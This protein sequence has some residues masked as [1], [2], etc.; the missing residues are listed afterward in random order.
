MRAVGA[1]RTPQDFKSR[2]ERAAKDVP[3]LRH[4][5]ASQWLIRGALN[6]QE[7]MLEWRIAYL[8]NIIYRA[9]PSIMGQAQHT[10]SICWAPPTW[11]N[12]LYSSA[13]RG[14]ACLPGAH[15]PGCHGAL[16]SGGGR[17]DRR[18]CGCSTT[19]VC[20]QMIL[21][22]PISNGGLQPRATQRNE[23]TVFHDGMTNR[24]DL[25]RKPKDRTH[26]PGSCCKNMHSGPLAPLSP[27]PCAGKCRLPRARPAPQT[28]P[29][30]TAPPGGVSS[31]W[32]PMPAAPTP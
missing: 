18:C 19:G 10:A 25:H 27:A 23:S 22:D 16:D 1:A 15:A 29:A 30:A 21:L 12:L 11:P 20:R 9:R 2:E 14:A 17:G 24:M 26:W 8:G 4:Q 3:A 32:A 6:A 31:R 5:K 13:W 7:Q 28:W